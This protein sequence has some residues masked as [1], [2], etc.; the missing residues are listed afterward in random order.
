MQQRG[1]EELERIKQL[2]MEKE[3]ERN[4]LMGKCLFNLCDM[5]PLW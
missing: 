2:L 1:E 3:A 4:A 5:T